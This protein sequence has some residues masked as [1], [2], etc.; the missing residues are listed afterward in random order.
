ME[1]PAADIIPT[2]A[3]V[4]GDTVVELVLDPERAESALAVASDGN[5]SIERQFRLETGQVLVPYSAG[6]NLIAHRC[7]LLASR[8]DDFGTK[9]GLLSDVRSFL[10]RYVDLS[11]TFEQIAAHY[12]LLTWLYDAFAEVPYL[13]FRGDYGTGKTRGLIAI[14]SLC[15]KGFFAAGAS[16][17]SPIFHTLD[18]FGGTLIL[19]EA[20]FR[21]SDA[22]ADLVKLFNNGNVK[23]LPVLRTMQNRSKEF[24]PVAFNV[25]GPKVIA[26]RGSFDDEAL[27]SRFITEETGARP[28]RADIPLHVP[29]SLEIEALA[30]RNR[31]LDYRLRHRFST[32]PCPEV[33]IARLDPRRNQIAMPLLSLIDD[34]AVRDEVGQLL[35]SQQSQSR[36]ARGRTL[37]AGVL[38]A[39]IAALAKAERPVPVQTIADLHNANNPGDLP[40]TARR[41]GAVLR[42]TFR[43]QTRKSHGNFVVDLDAKQRLEGFAPRFGIHNNTHG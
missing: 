13:R 5:S 6:N 12:V 10:H 7:V 37:A 41:T 39:T 25:F 23:G 11:P 14:G 36:E 17:V 32:Y 16:T 33:C 30:L 38:K 24:N 40:V 27:E 8:P 19:D 21:F 34:S 20:D 35:L 29:G 15:N 28:L 43:I 31:L 4:S 26:M 3:F 9:E 1:P 18:R 22:T 2:V 42:D